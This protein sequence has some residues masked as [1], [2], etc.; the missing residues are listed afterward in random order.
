MFSLKFGG[1]SMGSAEN[2]S[3][4]ANIIIHHSEKEKVVTVSAITGITDLLLQSAK[5]SMKEDEICYGD[6]LGDIKRIHLDILQELVK[7]PKLYR[8]GKEFITKKLADLSEF[9]TALIVV[10]E[11]SSRS[12]DAIISVGEILS[13]YLLFLHL[14]DRGEKSF[15]INLENIIPTGCKKLDTQFFDVFGKQLSQLLLPLLKKNITPICT[16][17]FGKIPG[18]IISVVGRGYSDFTAALI[19]KS[20]KAKEIQIWTDVSGILSTDPRIVSQAHVIDELS[21]N[22]A[23]ELAN[24]GAK[25][26]HP[27]TIWP[28]VK[29]NILVRI[30]NTMAPKDKGTAITWN[31][32]DSGKAFKSI[33][34][35]KDIT[36]LTVRMGDM[37]ESGLMEKL[38]HQFSIHNVSIDLIATSESSISVTIHK[39]NEYIPDLVQGLEKTFLVNVV[40]GKTIIAIVGHEM[41]NRIG[42]AGRFFSALASKKINVRMI[43][44]GA[45][46]ANISAVIDGEYSNDAVIVVHK[47]FFGK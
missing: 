17:F 37:S 24:L 25:V 46:E 22:E 8:E 28:A 16:G 3:Q 20:C 6:V 43:S 44:Q 12:N 11:I 47:E 9:L 4:T 40:E 18:G 45:N 2:I 34:I 32:N 31:G 14:Q 35:Q 19:G 39:G 42:V 10:G 21:F 36:M 41:R 15:F 30:K 23:T 33:T 13:A 7:N 38:F 27:Q 5:C 29:D 1:T 26:I